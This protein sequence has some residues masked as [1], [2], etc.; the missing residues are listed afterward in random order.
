M[1]VLV[2]RVDGGVVLGQVGV[3][4]EALEFALARVFLCFYVGVVWV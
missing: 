3:R 4:G 2:E 1:R